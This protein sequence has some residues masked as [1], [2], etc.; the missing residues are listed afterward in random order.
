MFVGFEYKPKP[1][2][3]ALLTYTLQ[4]RPCTS[5]MVRVLS[6]DRMLTPRLSLMCTAVASEPLEELAPRGALA[7]SDKAV[8]GW[9]TGSGQRFDNGCGDQ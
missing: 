3:T 5:M 9:A 7:V 6:Y 2:V 1:K 8:S 4:V